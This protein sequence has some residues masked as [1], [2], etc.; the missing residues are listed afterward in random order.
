MNK[1]LITIGAILTGSLY[2]SYKLGK[3]NKDKEFKSQMMSILKGS[4]DVTQPRDIL[5]DTEEEA[6]SVL[7]GLNC[8]V[9]EYGQVSIADLYDLVGE[10][11]MYSDTFYGWKNIDDVKIVKDKHGFQLTLPKTICFQ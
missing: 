11:P 1:K 4:V 7:D 5:F 8:I 10:R 9:C 6:Q 3:Y 2:L